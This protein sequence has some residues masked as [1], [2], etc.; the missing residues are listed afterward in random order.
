MKKT[1]LSSLLSAAV[2]AAV[3][4]AAAG[5]EEAGFLTDPT[6]ELENQKTDYVPRAELQFPYFSTYYVKPTVTTEESVALGF[7]VT[8]FFQSEIRRFDDSHR[9][10]AH[11]EYGR[12]G[13]RGTR[14]A[15]LA[16]KAGDGSFALGRLKAGD[17]WLRA[18]AVD[19]Q[20]RESHRVFHRFRV[21]AP[22]SDALPANAVCRITTADLAAYGIRNDGDIGRE[23]LVEIGPRPEKENLK[24]TVARASKAIDAFL[25]TNAA[26]AVT[27]PG[28]VVCKPTENG[29]VITH[30]WRCA[31]VVWDQGVDPEAVE[32]TAKATAEGLQKLLDDKA[33]AGI[34]KLVLPSGTYRIS[35]LSTVKVPTNFTLDLNGATIKVNGF[36]GAHGCAV[37]LFRCT[38]SHLVSG[39]IEGDYWEHDYAKSENGSEWPLGFTLKGC[40]YSTVENV[41]V[42]DIT[43]YGVAIGG[44][45]FAPKAYSEF[46]L[47]F[48][49]WTSGGLDPKT[50]AVNAN[51]TDRFTCDFTSLEK[52]QQTRR[53]QISKYLGYQGRDTRSW[54]LVVAWYDAEKNFLASETCWQYREMMIPEKAAF[55]RCSIE[56]ESLAAAKKCRLRGLRF[57]PSWNCA[58][59]NCTVD[60]ARC[61]GIAPTAMKNV[62]FEG[63]F[64]T[65]SGESKARCAFDAEDGW[66]QMQDVYFLRNRLRDNPVNNSLLT[67]CGHNFIFEKTD[68]G[69]SL[70]GRTH[71][72]VVRDNDLTSANFACDS[73]LRT[74]YVRIS[75]NRYRG[76]LR[77]GNKAKIPGWDLVLKGLSFSGKDGVRISAGETG[78]FVDCTFSDMEIA[79]VTAV[80]CRLENC[81]VERLPGA[82]W[83]DVKMKGGVLQTVYA[84]CSFTGCTFDGVGFRNLSALKGDVCR[85]TW[86]DCT[87]S[88][89]SFGAFGRA[90]H[91]WTNCTFRDFALSGVYWQLPGSLRFADCTVVTPQAKPFISLGLYAVGDLAFDR[92]RVTGGQSLVRINDLRKN[93]D[94]TER[95]SGRIS[96]ART[97]C[98]DVSYAIDLP[99][100]KKI[101]KM[102]SSRKLVIENGGGNAFAPGT[103]LVDTRCLPGTWEVR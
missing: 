34:R 47:S 50:G 39:T 58:I 18:W 76:T 48:K 33:A 61:V 13:E 84:P 22:G 80:G 97:T 38:D 2:A 49:G 94:E 95:S 83:T 43:G 57:R 21:I 96:V 32:A 79:P 4:T 26:K 46:S 36:T 91:E 82:S 17:W 72:S 42:R 101:S 1:L 40:E 81:T 29:R 66:D 11:L 6:A 37:G 69:L 24:Q 98:A 67:C 45:G 71:S 54:Q 89:G 23:A 64:I 52:V 90:R 15:P 10:T 92:C 63:N 31:R 87:F 85:A 73:R 28:Y 16:V 41:T 44:H 56:E 100:A 86:K 65:R 5:K 99:D 70:H 93:T 12:D 59:R 77:F 14:L 88:G 3:G 20:G 60:R 53:M 102:T 9:F 78:R 74:G 27:R 68:G 75:N 62:L 8:D 7:Y 55:M 103:A 51:E 25:A 35:G 30:A 19:A